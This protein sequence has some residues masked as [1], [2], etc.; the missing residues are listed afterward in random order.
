[1]TRQLHKKAAP[2]SG[3]RRGGGSGS[4]GGRLFAGYVRT[5]W[6]ASHGN[7]VYVYEQAGEDGDWGVVRYR[8]VEP[9]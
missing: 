6:E 2:R 4:D 5:R 3:H 8:L 7:Y 9:F 1:M